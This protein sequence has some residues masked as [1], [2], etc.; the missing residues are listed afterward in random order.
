MSIVRKGTGGH[1]MATVKVDPKVQKLHRVA[2]GIQNG[3]DRMSDERAYELA[4]QALEA[5]GY[6]SLAATRRWL[7]A[8]RIRYNF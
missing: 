8:N 2:A 5:V 6:A 7:T 3:H 4:T 1:E